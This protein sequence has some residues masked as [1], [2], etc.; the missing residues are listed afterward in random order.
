MDTL[1]SPLDQYVSTRIASM[2]SRDIDFLG[3]QRH[4]FLCSCA[5]LVDFADMVLPP[6]KQRHRFLRYE[7]LEYTDSDILS[8]LPEEQLL[9]PA[10]NCMVHCCG[11]EFRVLNCYDQKSLLVHQIRVP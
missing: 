5:F 4:R 6:R 8:C 10:L 1:P 9:E 7:G 3:K 11:C 2:V